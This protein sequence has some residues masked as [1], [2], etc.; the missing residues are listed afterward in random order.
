MRLRRERRTL[1]RRIC[2][3]RVYT[4]EGFS[5]FLGRIS[6]GDIWWGL[7]MK[8]GHIRRFALDCQAYVTIRHTKPE[9]FNRQADHVEDLFFAHVIFLLRLSE[10]IHLNSIHE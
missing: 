7:V 5:G 4:C 2:D 9:N 6:C 8:D 1:S 3:G 10:S